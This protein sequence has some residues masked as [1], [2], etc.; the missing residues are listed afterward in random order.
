MQ[1]SCRLANTR[2]VTHKAAYLSSFFHSSNKTHVCFLQRSMKANIGL[3]HLAI[4]IYI[5]K[6]T[7]VDKTVIIL[8]SLIPYCLL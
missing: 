1:Y 6:Y 2:T 3:H 7:H 4:W 8:R 5:E